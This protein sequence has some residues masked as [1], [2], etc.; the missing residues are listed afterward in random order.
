MDKSSVRLRLLAAAGIAIFAALV[1]S[2]LGLE[3]LFQRHVERRAADELRT[4]MRALLAGLQVDNAGV[5]TIART[6]SDQRY[7]QAFSG[8]YWQIAHDGQV[9]EKSRSLWDEELTLPDDVLPAGRHHLHKI[10]GPRASTLLAVEKAIVV[11]RG[12]QEVVF[13]ATVALDSSELALAVKAFRFELVLG[14]GSLGAALLAA[15][16]AA[17]SVGLAPLA[18]LRKALGVL[19]SG[20]ASRLVGAYPSEVQPL[21]D[22][23]NELLAQQ[24]RMVAKAQTRAANLAHGLKTPL[25]AISAMAEEFD[26]ELQQDIAQE[27]QSHVSTMQRHLE[28]ELALARS[29][30]DQTS[31]R[32][33][34]LHEFIDRL[35][36]TMQ[37]LPRG[38]ELQWTVTI[39]ELLAL[40]ID[41]TTLGEIVGN[42]LDNARKWARRSV[43]I[44]AAKR[45]HWI[46]LEFSDD[47][48]GVPQSERESI[49]RRGE[50]L[51]ENQPGS[52]LGLSIVADIVGELGGTIALSEAGL[53]G[54]GVRIRIPKTSRFVVDEG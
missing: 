9:L 53:G 35:V 17:L 34:V 5:L 52:G 6:P 26:Q 15:F 25:T 12:V 27:L 38:D 19:R 45:G 20:D 40:K 1:V 43:H 37:R 39:D 4:D 28:H 31:A 24:G 22:D 8:L 44:S 46:E 18:R 49:V 54:L 42:I 14:L 21:V 47:G 2:G 3:I 48:P 33:I 36:R 23:L 32:T 51:D 30:P 41:E 11:K 10:G 50:R 13:R 16:W 7:S 29:A